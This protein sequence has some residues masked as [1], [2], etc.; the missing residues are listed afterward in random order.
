MNKIKSISLAVV[1][2][3]MAFIFLGCEPHAGRDYVVITGIPAEYNEQKGVVKIESY[4]ADGIVKN[5]ELTV[6]FGYNYD[7]TSSYVMVEFENNRFVYTNG[8]A[9]EELQVD[10]CDL[11]F[12]AK[13]PMVKFTNQ[14][15]ER[16]CF[17]DT[18]AVIEFDKF[19]EWNTDNCPDD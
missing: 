3:A 15:G 13:L 4:R 7:D 17:D 19:Q 8:K 2:V 18:A 6:F 12:F 10:V 9:F 14:R 1:V 16:F 5:G 11:S